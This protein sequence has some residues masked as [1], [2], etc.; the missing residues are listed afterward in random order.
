ME[1]IPIL[2]MGRFLLVTIQVDMHDRLAMTLQEDLD[3]SYRQRP[4]ARRVARYFL[5]GN[6]RLL[7]RPHDRPHCRR[8]SRARCQNRGGGNETCRRHHAGRIG[9]DPRWSEHR[10]ECRYR[11][12]DVERLAGRE[13]TT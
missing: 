12:G 11:Y 9:H 10:A 2:K 3:R 6:R 4:R 7:Y 1:R 13:G 8:L 5:A